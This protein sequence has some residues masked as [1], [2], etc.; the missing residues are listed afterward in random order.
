[1]SNEKMI[2]VEQTDDITTELAKLIAVGWSETQI[3]RLARIRATYSQTSDELNAG[4][5]QS[6]TEQNRMAFARWLYSVGR[7]TS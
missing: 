3:A 1:M 4:V 2:Y 7:M 6:K 5:L